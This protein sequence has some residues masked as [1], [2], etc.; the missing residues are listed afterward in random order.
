MMY[1]SHSEG[2]IKYSV[3]VDGER[4]LGRK[5]GEA[6]TGDGNWLRGDRVKR[7]LGVRKKICKG[8]E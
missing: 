2:K 3:E 1:E 5:R 6:G 8:W 7:W 4:E